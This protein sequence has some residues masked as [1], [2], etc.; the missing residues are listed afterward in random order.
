NGVERTAG[1]TDAG[2]SGAGSSG[3]GSSGARSSG[4]RGG[5]VPA[6]SAAAHG[7][8]V[9]LLRCIGYLRDRYLGWIFFYGIAM[10]TLEHVAVTVLQ[11]WLTDVLGRS[12]D[13]VGATPLFSGL[14]FA[15]FSII[16]A[17]SARVSAP[18][19]ERFGTMATLIGLA[20]L[21]AVIVTGM[22]IWVSAAVLALV[23]FRSAQGAAAPVLISAAVAPRV[24]RRHRATLLSLNSL[25]GRLG[26]GLFLLLVSGAVAD[27]V[28]PV[29]RI[30][31]IV[32]WT[33]VA[34]L[35]CSAVLV[36]RAAEPA[37]A[38]VG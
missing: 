7:L 33:L 2:P 15:S 8:G 10:V 38:T 21:S 22:A 34:V 13:D 35:I 28:Q 20:A 14:V 37:A 24:E 11:P 30:F 31:S 17:A 27:D 25:A 4:A 18:L 12:P 23:A 36:R 16:G 5:P 26:Y 1:P 3:A 19:A 32:A 9:Q 6:E 29:L